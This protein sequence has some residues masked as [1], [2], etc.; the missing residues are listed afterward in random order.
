MIG[1]LKAFS[2]A[3]VSMLALGAV[4]AASASAQFEAE[5]VPV[6]AT[7][8]AN[9]TQA[10]TYNTGDGITVQC[11]TVGGSGE[12]T[13]TPS[14]DFRF[15]PTYTGCT[16]PAINGKAEVNM[17]GCGYTFTSAA[18]ATSMTTHI[19][20]PEGK[21]IDITI[22][23]SFGSHLCTLNVGPQTPA[24]TITGSNLGSGTT[25][26]VKIASN[27]SG[28]VGTRTGSSFCGPATSITGCYKGEVT[29]TGENPTTNAH[30]GIFLD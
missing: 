3:L 8:S 1:N 29:T 4:V 24:G 21:S 12:Q 6:R 27:L 28:I 9:T 30:I 22:F 17:T 10:F 18:K 16:V 26:E 14:T 15:N 5:S 20:C 7:R 13:V 2:L 25:R 11:T 23:D 19:V